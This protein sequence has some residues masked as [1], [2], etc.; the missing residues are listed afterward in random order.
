[1]DENQRKEDNQAGENQAQPPTLGRTAQLKSAQSLVTFGIIAG[2]VSMLL[3]GV[4]V[5]S[6][7]LTCSIIAYVKVRGVISSEGS[8]DATA[9][10]IQ[11][12]ALVALAVSAVALVFNGIYLAITLPSVI[13]AVNSGDL[14]T[15]FDFSNVLGQKTPPAETPSIWG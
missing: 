2:P 7:A 11:R 6:I 9:R 3:G 13:E 5:S 15:M 4:L 12:Q 10:A 8:A 1:M 14:S